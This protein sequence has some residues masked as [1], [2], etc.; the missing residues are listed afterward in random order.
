[1]SFETDLRGYLIANGSPVK[2]LIGTRVYPVVLPQNVTY[3]ALQYSTVSAQRGYRMTG[4]NY[5]PMQR[6]QIDAWALTYAE[7]RSL[8]DAAR[9]RIESF[10]GVMGA[11]NVQGIFFD[12]ERHLNEV[13]GSTV[14]YRISADYLC[15]FEE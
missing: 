2:T 13:T 11:T 4:P 7:A 15:W 6:V 9:N 8:A 14:L 1:M 5:L 10:R 12:T 3:P